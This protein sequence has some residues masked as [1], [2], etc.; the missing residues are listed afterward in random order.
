MARV[1]QIDLEIAL[2]EDLIKWNPIDAGG[3]HGYRLYPTTTQPVG[4]TMQVSC[5]TLKPAYWFWISI[6]PHGDVMRCSPHRFPQ[7]EDEPP[8]GPGPRIVIVAPTPFFPSDFARTSC[9]PSSR[10]SSHGKLVIRFGPVTRVEES[11]QRGQRALELN[12][13]ATMLAIASTGAM[14]SCGHEKHQ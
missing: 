7:T 3:L 9:L 4:H 12:A 5:K 2:F 8:P 10:I 11:L 14:L 6:R 13:L 1:Y